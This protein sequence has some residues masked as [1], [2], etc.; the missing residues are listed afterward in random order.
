MAPESCHSCS[1]QK[2]AIKPSCKLD[3][4]SLFLR[5]SKADMKALPDPRNALPGN[6]TVHEL[7]LSYDMTLAEGGKITPKIPAI[8]NYVYDGELGGQITVVCDKNK[9]VI[10]VGDIYPEAMQVK[11]GDYT[12][13]VCLRHEH[14]LS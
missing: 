3:A 12:I 10:G 4:L 11:K 2:R 7:V 6:R 14:H 1:I 5:P 9:R 13:F 8:N